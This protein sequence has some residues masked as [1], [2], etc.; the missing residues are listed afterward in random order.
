[1]LQSAVTKQFE[2]IGE[3]AYH[4]SK[5]LKS[6]H[7]HI[8][9]KRMEGMRHFLVHDYYEIAPKVLWKTKED[10]IEFLKEDIK[11]IL[12]GFNAR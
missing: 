6:S 7:S 11:K 2:I 12:E 9:W 1:M 10:F 3:A 8:A 5:E 4:V